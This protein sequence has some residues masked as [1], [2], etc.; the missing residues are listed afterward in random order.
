VTIIPLDPERLAAIKAEHQVERP[1]YL[2]T[3]EWWCP[4]CNIYLE[5][6]ARCLPYRLAATAIALHARE[7]AFHNQAETYRQ[8]IGALAAECRALHTRLESGAS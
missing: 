7:Q 8:E 5:G 4:S 3:E 6:D 1:T 2:I